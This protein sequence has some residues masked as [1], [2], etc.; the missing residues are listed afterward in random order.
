MALS[1]SQSTIA[2]TAMMMATRTKSAVTN[3]AAPFQHREY[4]EPDEV[5]SGGLCDRNE[6]RHGQQQHGEAVHERPEHK[7]DC[8]HQK[9]DE[10]RLIDDPREHAGQ[11]ERQ[12]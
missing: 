11:R 3:G 12:T 7:V 5:D 2:G 8:Q 1:G 10:E 4:A 6:Q 9:N